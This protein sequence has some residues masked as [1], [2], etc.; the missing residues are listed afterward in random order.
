[1]AA[2][3][4]LPFPWASSGGCWVVNVHLVLRL[5]AV[6]ALL[7]PW[8]YSRRRAS[9][10][11]PWDLSATPRECGRSQ[12]PSLVSEWCGLSSWV[13]SCCLLSPVFVSSPS[14]FR[15]TLGPFGRLW[16]F[17][18]SFM[19]LCRAPRVNCHWSPV[20]RVWSG[21]AEKEFRGQ[22]G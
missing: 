1:M 10:R 7:V 18:V 11:F 9:L 12:K 15:V 3:G 4:A 20:G 19:P 22:N 13:P 8:A 2:V 21:L 6:G 16:G 17:G 5:A 14:D